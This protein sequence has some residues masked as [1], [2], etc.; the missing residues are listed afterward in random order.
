MDLT[1]TLTP[2]QAAAIRSLDA[3]RPIATVI[4]IHVD[5]WLLPIV[6]ALAA[7]EREAVSTAYANAPADDRATVRSVLKVSD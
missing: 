7:K 4:Q 6:T 1:V 5:T 3:K 2:A